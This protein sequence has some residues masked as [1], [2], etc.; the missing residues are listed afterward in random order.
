MD[1][2]AVSPGHSTYWYTELLASFINF[3]HYCSPSSGFYGAGKDNRSRCTDNLSGSHPIWTIGA[4]RP[5]LHHPPIFCQMP[6]LPQLS[7][8]ILAWDR[9]RIML[10]CIPVAGPCVQYN[11]IL[12]CIIHSFLSSLR[13]I[14]SFASL[15]KKTGTIPHIWQSLPKSYQLSS[16]PKIYNC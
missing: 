14:L 15:T 10:A 9:H 1:Q 7:Q 2:Y 8:F 12:C 11:E 16:C 5:H 3:L 4:P 13:C 6:F